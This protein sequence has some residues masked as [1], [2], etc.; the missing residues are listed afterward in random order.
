MKE[1]IKEEAKI[2]EADNSIVK[3]SGE[4]LKDART[5][6]NENKAFSFPLAELSTLGAGVSS[7]IPAFNTVTQTA[8]ISMD[9]LLRV[10]NAGPGQV[11]QIAKDGSY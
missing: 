11:L 8:T 3:L 10:A 5:S 4:L 9:G 7:L 2:I 1:T 6:I